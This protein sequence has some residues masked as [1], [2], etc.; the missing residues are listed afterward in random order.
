LGNQAVY[1]QRQKIFAKEPWLN[2]GGLDQATR[3]GHPELYRGMPSAA[4]AQRQ[5]KI[6]HEQFVSYS[7]AKAAYMADSSKFKGMPRLP[8]YSKK[9]RTFVVARNGYQG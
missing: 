1:I 5:I 9:Y 2:Y 8:G 4:S 3:L 6:V 7:A